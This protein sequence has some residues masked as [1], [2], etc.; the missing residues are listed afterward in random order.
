MLKSAL[1]P[2]TTA[3]VANLSRRRKRGALTLVFMIMLLDIVGI[4]ILSPVAPYLVRR[5]S[6]EA[7]AVTMIP[8]LYAAGQFMAAP[9]LG[10][11]GDR[12]GRRPVLLAS[13]VGQGLSY[14]IF[15]VGGAL[16][17]LFL[18][19]L[20]GGF[21]GGNLSTANAY[22]ADVSR[23]EERTKNFMLIGVAWSLGLII[24]PAVG[25]VFGQI[26]L[27]APAFVAAALAFVNV[28][29]GIFVLPESLPKEQRTAVPIRLG[30]FNPLGAIVSVARKPGL[31]VLLLTLTLFSF[32]FNGINS[33]G[34]L[35]VIE[36]F[37]AQPWQTG[38]LLVGGG[39]ALGVVQFFLV[40]R[41]VRRY[42]D[43]RMAVASLLMQA[44][45][46]LAIFWSP[47]FWLV[48]LFNMVVAG[49]SGFTFP[50]LT[51][52]STEL[53][54]PREVGLLLGVTTALGSLTNIFGPLWAG[55]VY[56]RVMLGAPYWMG[57]GIFVL[58][59]LVLT[60]LRAS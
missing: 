42:G 29:V 39:V 12:Y 6:P 24:G 28:G 9:V 52:L 30:D 47:A 14:V 37:S 50:T 43:R 38:L 16:W 21:T 3:S 11:L 45:G 20:V 10:K 17:V 22:I 57:A 8:V 19:R 54:P 46:N 26:S 15:G 32:A 2:E 35:F 33:T 34:T 58:A 13:L 5:Y 53:V 31:G 48:F 36:K 44:V 18:A 1:S 56:D 40:E 4:A 55:A 60:F 23:P 49:A 25:A 27:E 41:L 7:I 51:T 59:A